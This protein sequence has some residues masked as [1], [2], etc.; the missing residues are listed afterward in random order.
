MNRENLFIAFLLLSLFLESTLI[1]FPFVFLTSLLFYIIYP[2]VRT[3]ILT[4][5]FGILTDIANVS[6]IGQTTLAI[7]IAYLFIELYKRAF[8]TRDWRIILLMLFIATYFY[9]SVFIYE[10]SLLIYLLFFVC[11]GVVINYFV[12]KKTLWLK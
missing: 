2:D 1:F 3:V 10:N 7:L 12:H 9:A 6:I 8:D 5:F 11:V 4:A